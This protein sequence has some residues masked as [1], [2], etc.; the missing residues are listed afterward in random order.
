M[1]QFKA[2]SKPDVLLE[3]MEKNI[4]MIRGLIPNTSSKQTKSSSN[5]RDSEERMKII[6]D[7]LKEANK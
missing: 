5:V 2:I 4:K 1:I 6:S 3:E 7:A